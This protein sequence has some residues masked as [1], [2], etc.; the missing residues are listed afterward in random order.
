MRRTPTRI[1]Q[2]L[3]FSALIILAFFYTHAVFH[4]LWQDH[5]LDQRCSL[6]VFL[7]QCSSEP[8]R[9]PDL[10]LSWVPSYVIALV[11]QSASQLF[12]FILPLVRAPPTGVPS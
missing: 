12:H 2:R 10:K 4:H 1:A 9:V 7:T 5:P 11:N 8:Y 3:A 6:V